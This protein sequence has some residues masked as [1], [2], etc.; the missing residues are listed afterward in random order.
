MLDEGLELDDGT[1]RGR[2][3]K[4]MAA[5]FLYNVTGNQAWEN[6]VNAESVCAGGPARVD[7]S[8][9]KPALG[10]RRLSGHSAGR[11]LPGAAEQHEDADH[12]R[13]Q[14]RRGGPHRQ[15][16][17]AARNGSERRRLFWRTAQNVDRTII[18]HAVA[19]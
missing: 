15:P 5:A 8:I 1:V 14:E 13:G 6:V 7:N 17:L 3:F 2:D 4:M 10:Y 9:Q 11:S 12:R 16:T 19:D 18:A